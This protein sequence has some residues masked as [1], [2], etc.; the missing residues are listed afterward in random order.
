LNPGYL[1]AILVWPVLQQNMAAMKKKHQ[2]WFKIFSL[3]TAKAITEQLQTLMIHKRMLD[4]MES[5][6][7]LQYSLEKRRS[8]RILGIYRHRYFR[9]ALDFLELRAESGEPLRETAK[10]WRKF[11]GANSE[12]R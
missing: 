5:I 11:E 8:N 9:A 4:M 6:W 7:V 12:Q 1:F 2:I 10:W 3:S